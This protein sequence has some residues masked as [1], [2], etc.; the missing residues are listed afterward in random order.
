MEEEW[1]EKLEEEME[2][3]EEDEKEEQHK[4]ILQVFSCPKKVFCELFKGLF[5]VM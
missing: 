1:Q 3:E 5:K 2:E 4:D